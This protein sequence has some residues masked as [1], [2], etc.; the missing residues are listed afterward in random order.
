MN[1]QTRGDL[2]QKLKMLIKHKRNPVNKAVVY[3]VPST[4]EEAFVLDYLNTKIQTRRSTKTVTNHQIQSVIN[5][6]TWINL[7][8]ESKIE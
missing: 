2:K 5:L 4:E 8:N 1:S 3:Q 7:E 6:E